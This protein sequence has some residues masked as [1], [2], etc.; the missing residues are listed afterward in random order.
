MSRKR[1]LWLGAGV[2]AVLL[3]VYSLF[4]GESRTPLADK[5]F[6]AGYTS[7][8]TQHDMPDGTNVVNAMAGTCA[9]RITRSPGRSE[10]MV[11]MVNNATYPG[12]PANEQANP[13][14]AW[15]RDN[16]GVDCG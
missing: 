1:K 8:Q 7:V 10:F 9:V 16:V 3:V 4:S 14:R 6:G 5:A 12:I 15:L 11:V 2:L 13:L